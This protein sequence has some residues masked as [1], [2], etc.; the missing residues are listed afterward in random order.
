[1]TRSLAQATLNRER[2]L[3]RSNASN[4]VFR[5]LAKRAG[6]GRRLDT[7]VGYEIDP[8]VAQGRNVSAKRRLIIH[9]KGMNLTSGSVHFR[10]RLARCSWLRHHLGMRVVL[11]LTSLLP[12]LIRSDQRLVTAVSNE[13]TACAHQA[14]KCDKSLCASAKT[15]VNL[16]LSMK[17]ILKGLLAST[18][19]R[20]HMARLW[21]R[22]EMPTPC[23]PRSP[24]NPNA[25]QCTSLQTTQT[26]GTPNAMRE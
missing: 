11:L 5:L 25:T 15:G 10:P 3:F 21:Q 2:E 4:R 6:G 22:R 16:S 19:R 26:K 1:M 14:L 17:P 8:T 12:L 7:N 9:Q 20:Q 24:A 13:Y 23:R 18:T